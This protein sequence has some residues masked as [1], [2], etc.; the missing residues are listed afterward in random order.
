LTA[1]EPCCELGERHIGTL[2]AHLDR[3][4]TVGEPLPTGNGRPNLPAIAIACG[5]DRQTLHKDP[6][7]KALLQGVVDAPGLAQSQE[8]PADEPEASPKP[9]RRFLQLEQH[10]ATLRA[11]IRGLREQFARYRHSEAVMISG[12]GERS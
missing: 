8:K 6:K 4:P 2:Q 11:E 10:D 3:L 1:S 9:E 12:R 7:A 5:F